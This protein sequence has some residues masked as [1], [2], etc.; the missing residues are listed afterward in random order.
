MLRCARYLEIHGI[1]LD[2]LKIV[3]KVGNIVPFSDDDVECSDSGYR[4]ALG[5]SGMAV[6]WHSGSSGG[7]MWSESP[8]TGSNESAEMRNGVI[9]SSKAEHVNGD[10]VPSRE[11]NKSSREGKGTSNII[12][13]II[14]VYLNSNAEML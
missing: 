4:G 13:V 12:L 5:D 7:R 2:S 1:T 14:H 10:R 9:S 6:D 8:R 11:S 3:D